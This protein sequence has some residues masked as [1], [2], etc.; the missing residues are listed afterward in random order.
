ML[1]G[2]LIDDSVEI[3]ENGTDGLLLS[4]GEG[5]R[6]RKLPDSRLTEGINCSLHCILQSMFFKRVLHRPIDVLSINTF[7]VRNTINPLVKIEFSVVVMENLSKTPL[8]RN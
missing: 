4:G 6:E 1:L 2:V 3:G 5:L 8:T 7:K